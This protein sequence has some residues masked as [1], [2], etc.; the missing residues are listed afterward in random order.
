MYVYQYHVV[1]MQ[2]S[3]AAYRK[4]AIVGWLLM[5]CSSTQVVRM[6]ISRAVR[7]LQSKANQK[8]FKLSRNWENLVLRLKLSIIRNKNKNKFLSLAD[9]R[10]G[11][12]WT[13]VY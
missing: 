2:R 5:E 8:S 12:N 11:L 3:N 6:C 4:D 9:D 1:Y 13:I 10:K 7:K